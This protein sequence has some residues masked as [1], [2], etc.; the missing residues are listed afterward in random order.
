MLKTEN[1]NMQSAARLD[2]KERSAAIERLVC[3]PPLSES[4]VNTVLSNNQELTGQA[5]LGHGHEAPSKQFRR[6]QEDPQP[7]QCRS[8]MGVLWC[9]WLEL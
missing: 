8:S 2:F 5:G 4:A 3:L 1:F 9:T 6:Q 7:T